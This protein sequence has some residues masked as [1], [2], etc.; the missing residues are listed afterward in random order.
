MLAL[1]D[2][3]TLQARAII[4]RRGLYVEPTSAV[5]IAALKQFSP[6]GVTVIPLT[7]SGLKSPKE[8]RCI[9]G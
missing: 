2:E 1:T 9:D 3:E 8:Y 4:A 5:A 6:G 7:G